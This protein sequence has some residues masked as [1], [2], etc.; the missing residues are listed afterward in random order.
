MQIYP[1]LTTDSTNRIKKSLY[2][3]FRGLYR[4]RDFTPSIFRKWQ[5]LLK[6]LRNHSNLRVLQPP[7][8]LMILFLSP[9][10]GKQIRGWTLPL[11]RI[12]CHLLSL[13]L[14]IHRLI[15]TICP[16]L[17]CIYDMKSID[18]GP[19]ERQQ[20]LAYAHSRKSAGATGPRDLFALR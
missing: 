14:R 6:N 3:Y 20:E 5:Q 2:F 15:L 10:R 18:L 1:C 12:V 17:S 9:V 11:W 19:K 13:L 4:D 7:M 16:T 8:H